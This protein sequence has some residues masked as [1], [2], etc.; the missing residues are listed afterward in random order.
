MGRLSHL[1]YEEEAPAGGF[2]WKAYRFS[3]DGRHVVAGL[4]H[5]THTAL[6]RDGKDSLQAVFSV[7]KQMLLEDD[8]V[9]HICNVDDVPFER[10]SSH[11]VLDWEADRLRRHEP[12][13]VGP[14]E[15]IRR[16]LLE[17]AYRC[18]EEN[19]TFLSVAKSE[20]PVP[21]NVLLFNLRFLSD[22]GYLREGEGGKWYNIT[23]QGIQTIERSRSRDR[24][25]GLA[26]IVMAFSA[27]TEALYDK[28][29]A[30][31]VLS[32]GLQPVRID[33]YRQPE[34]ITEGIK[35]LIRTADVVVADLTLSRPNCYYELGYAQAL[36]RSVVLCAREDHDPRQGADRQLRVH[37]DVDAYNIIFWSTDGWD[38]LE[39]RLREAL[40]S[41]L[42]R[43]ANGVD[44]TFHH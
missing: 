18:A 13:I 26:F 2:P 8:V 39:G 32:T 37:F 9:P 10:L 4:S 20:I 42:S 25:S 17:L 28:S 3:I 24:R 14:N 40:A 43:R 7:L 36:K 11:R 27:E 1:V 38:D 15:S 29:I 5:L 21:P 16:T 23:A 6:Q 30:P 34:T 44:G 41:E 35:T 12:I 22:A 19:T 31:A 33:R